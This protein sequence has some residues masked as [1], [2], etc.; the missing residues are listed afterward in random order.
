MRNTLCE[1]RPSC[2]QWATVAEAVKQAESAERFIGGE[3]EGNWVNAQ[4]DAEDAR[5]DWLDHVLGAQLA[6]AA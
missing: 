1:C 2:P 5:W 4:M 3:L 6:E